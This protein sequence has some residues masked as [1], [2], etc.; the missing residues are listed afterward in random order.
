MNF[1]RVKILKLNE[2]QALDKKINERLEDPYRSRNTDSTN[3]LFYE[4]ERIIQE[5]LEIYAAEKSGYTETNHQDRQLF[6]GIAIQPTENIH[7][8][9]QNIT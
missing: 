6:N 8:G 4:R 9:E 3:V 5:L 1:S 7:E 2:L